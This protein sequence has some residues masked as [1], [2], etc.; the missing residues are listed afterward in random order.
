MADQALPGA[1][2][3]PPVDIVLGVQ[4]RT[5]TALNVVSQ[6]FEAEIDISATARGGA[7]PG[8]ID[9]S[10]PGP[11]LAI[12]NGVSVD[13]LSDTTV[14]EG[15][16]RGDD[17]VWQLRVRGTFAES[18][19][20][21]R[22]PL[23]MQELGIE[24]QSE[25]HPIV[26]G[27]NVRTKHAMRLTFVDSDEPRPVTLRTSGV[28]IRGTLR[29][30]ALTAS[31]GTTFSGESKRSNVYAAVRAC[32]VVERRPGYFISNVALPSWI[33]TTLSA[34]SFAVPRE[35]LADR[36]SI[37]LTML[38][39]AAAYKI[40]V[41]SSLPPI[42]SLTLLDTYVLG[43]T[44]FTVL[45]AVQNVVG[46]LLGDAPGAERIHA[47]AVLAWL[48][49]WGVFNGLAAVW[50]AIVSARHRNLRGFHFK[51]LP[52]DPLVS[53]GADAVGARGARAVGTS[54]ATESQGAAGAAGSMS[55]AAPR[56]SLLGSAA[57]ATHTWLR[58]LDDDDELTARL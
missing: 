19:E 12:R 22:F 35:D 14:G 30:R 52:C 29:L 31:V 1:V 34:L 43:C 23:D 56:A 2:N 6:T 38:L 13:V 8:T 50:Y 27:P 54:T 55:S 58:S 33:A 15:T 28:T 4:F 45:A 40:I 44:A 48:V 7:V 41:S 37:T 25:R 11:S 24:V 47:A 5:L 18:L 46:A 32:V 20:L 53:R 51:Q 49:L 16:V 10:W 26:P 39:T 57:D 9:P 21:E 17:L 42:A 3:G 36:L